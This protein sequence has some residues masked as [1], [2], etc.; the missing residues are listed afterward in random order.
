MYLQPA[1]GKIRV[2]T[3]MVNYGVF[4]RAGMPRLNVPIYYDFMD[5]CRTIQQKFCALLGLN[6]QDEK[7]KKFCLK[8]FYEVKILNVSIGQ[9]I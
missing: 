4:S 1:P 5:S 3:W 7:R 8:L 9:E 2:K 6:V